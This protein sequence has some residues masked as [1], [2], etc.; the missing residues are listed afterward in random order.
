M[1]CPPTWESFEIL[2]LHVLSS[3]VCKFAINLFS[4]SWLWKMWIYYF[5]YQKCRFE[6]TVMHLILP[7]TAM[8]RYQCKSF[9]SQFR[10]KDV[11][12][13]PCDP[14]WESFEILLLHV[15]SN[16]AWQFAINVSPSAEG[17]LKML[18]YY[19]LYW[20]CRFETPWKISM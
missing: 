4:I 14:R 8:K 20:K 15:L 7:E 10:I 19:F 17:H 18:I 6:M 11:E 9:I 12:W 2:L 1:E 3:Y 16:D 13:T 5:S